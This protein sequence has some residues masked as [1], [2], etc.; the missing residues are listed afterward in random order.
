LFVASQAVKGE[1][2]LFFLQLEFKDVAAWEKKA[3]GL[4][5]DLLHYSPVLCD[6]RAETL[7][8]TD[9][10]DYVEERVAFNSTPDV[11]VPAFVLIPKRASL[12]APGIVGLHDHGGF[13]LW[14]KEKL[15]EQPDEHPVLAAFGDPTQKKHN[16]RANPTR[17]RNHRD[18]HVLLGR[19]VMLRGRR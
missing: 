16:E 13:Y 8:R 1:F 6:L 10:G 5:L 12:F 3:R 19:A 15:V 2:S 14:G 18:R 7:E 11:R 17:L 9:R 4:V